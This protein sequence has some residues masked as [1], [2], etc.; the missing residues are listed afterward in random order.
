[1]KLSHRFTTR[2]QTDNAQTAAGGELRVLAE[3]ELER[4]S[5]GMQNIDNPF[6]R[7][8]LAAAFITLVLTKDQ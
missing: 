2:P 6:V 5:G 4:V 7:A 3:D 8:V 1:M